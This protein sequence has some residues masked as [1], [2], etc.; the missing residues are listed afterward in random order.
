MFKNFPNK[1]WLIFTYMSANEKEK[2]EDELNEYKK[3][4]LNGKS[5][6]MNNI[7]K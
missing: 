7:F 3:F 6:E 5:N 1:N 2:D 4:V